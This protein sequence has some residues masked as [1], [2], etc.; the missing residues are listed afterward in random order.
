MYIGIR[1][2]NQTINHNHIKLSLDFIVGW[3]LQG[4][5]HPH[6]RTSRA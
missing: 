6:S 3:E 5:W 4:E 2:Y 1:S